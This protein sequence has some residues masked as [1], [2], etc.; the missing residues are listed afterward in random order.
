[1]EVIIFWPHTK[2]RI[3][4]LL[5]EDIFQAQL[6]HGIHTAGIQRKLKLM[7]NLISEPIKDKS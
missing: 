5:I 2:Q 7:Q 6:V 1:M 3:V 4:H